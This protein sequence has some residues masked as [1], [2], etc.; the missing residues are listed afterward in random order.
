MAEQIPN[1]KARRE[2]L[3]WGVSELARRANASDLTITVLENGG[4][5]DVAEARRILVALSGAEPRP[6]PAKPG[7]NAAIVPAKGKTDA[8]GL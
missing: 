5:C 2:A 8:P 7:P 1:L 6:A 3:G 4:G